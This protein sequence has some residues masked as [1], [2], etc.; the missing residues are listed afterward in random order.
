MRDDLLN[1]DSLRIGKP[2]PWNDGSGRISFCIQFRD[3]FQRHV[4]F[5]R[6]M[7]YWLGA[8][9]SK[10]TLMYDFDQGNPFWTAVIQEE[11]QTI[12]ILR[13]GKAIW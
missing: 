4:E 3:W 10:W 7:R 6:Q 9:T 11:D 2:T 1:T 5:D 13:F 8:N 12:F